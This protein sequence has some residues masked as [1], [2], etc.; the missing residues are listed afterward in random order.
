MQDN[1]LGLP[2][3]ARSEEVGTLRQLV[4]DAYTLYIERMGKAPGPMLD[5]YARRVADGQAWVLEIDHVIAGLIVLEDDGRS[6]LLDNVAVSPAAQGRGL[7]RRLIAF[8]EDEARRRGHVEV[9]L[10][11]NVLMAENIVLY[12]RLG[13]RK[14][15]LIREHGFDRQY[16][17]K[18]LDGV[19]TPREAPIREGGAGP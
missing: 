16:M 13:F 7:G 10:Y 19:A 9:R 18:A 1:T 4:T 2:R 8:A 11:T 14:T 15:E 6:L 12:E 5:D 3:L 17:T